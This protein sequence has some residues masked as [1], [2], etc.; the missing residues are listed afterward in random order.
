MS[1]DKLRLEQSVIRYLLPREGMSNDKGW[2][3]QRE[4]ERLRERERDSVRERERRGE[5]EIGGG[6]E[7]KKGGKECVR[8]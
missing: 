6:G 3:G 7:R 2:F 1:E 5:R 8:L 4:R